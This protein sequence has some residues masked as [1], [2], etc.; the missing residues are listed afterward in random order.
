MTIALG[1]TTIADCND[2][3]NATEHRSHIIALMTSTAGRHVGNGH[4]A[5]AHARKALIAS[6]ALFATLYASFGVV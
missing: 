1:A 6:V 3:S 2:L 4:S 5:D